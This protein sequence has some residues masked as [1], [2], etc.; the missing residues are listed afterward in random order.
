[1]RRS[2]AVPAARAAFADVDKVKGF[3][4]PVRDSLDAVIL[5]QDQADALL[6]SV[7]RR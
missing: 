1:V 2:V 7:T 5:T 3:L 4:A 6:L